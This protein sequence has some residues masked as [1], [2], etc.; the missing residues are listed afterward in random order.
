MKRSPLK[1]KNRSRFPG[2]RNPAYRAWV[3]TLGC[4]LAGKLVTARFSLRD[5][6][7]PLEAVGLTRIS[8]RWRHVCWGPI[9][10]VH[11]NETQ[12][13]GAYDVGEIVPLCR[14]AHRA[15]DQ[16]LGAAGFAQVT[17]LDLRAIAA[18]LV[19][20]YVEQGGKL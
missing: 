19:Q 3:R 11:V 7:D 18:G 1:R 4:V 5:Q 10:P 12:A 8:F 15:L 14:A 16:W 13:R 6:L 17:G 2:R 20:Q 9:D